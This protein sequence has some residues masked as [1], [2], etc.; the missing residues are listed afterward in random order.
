MTKSEKEQLTDVLEFLKTSKAINSYEI[1]DVGLIIR[2]TTDEK[3]DRDIDFLKFKIVMAG[4]VINKSF[5]DK[6]VVEI[7]E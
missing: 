7:V 2:I 4:T 3:D 1:D 6:L 5:E